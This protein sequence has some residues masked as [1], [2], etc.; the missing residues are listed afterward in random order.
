MPAVRPISANS[1]GPRRALFVTNLSVGTTRIC[2]LLQFPADPRRL[3]G[4][5]YRRRRARAST[6]IPGGL[7]LAKNVSGLVSLDVAE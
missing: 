5:F 1:G 2:A 4:L 7:S 6:M 3:L